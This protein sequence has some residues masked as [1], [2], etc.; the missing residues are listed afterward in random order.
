MISSMN[1]SRGG[2][3]ITF[4]RRLGKKAIFY[5]R[6]YHALAPAEEIPQAV[7]KDK[8]PRRSFKTYIKSYRPTKKH[9]AVA[10]VAVLVIGGGTY[11]LNFYQAR[12][13]AEQQAAVRA[14]AKRVE[15]ANAKAQ[16]CY[17]QK[18]EEKAAMLGKITFDQLYDGD[19]CTAE[20]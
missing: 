17:K 19:A 12:Q 13:Y 5:G 14:E 11:G 1:A 2:Q 8:K 20:Q 15:V 16:Q 18:T 10:V 9:F 6:I 4:V 3:P 7:K